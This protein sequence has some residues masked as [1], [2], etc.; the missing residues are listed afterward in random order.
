MHSMAGMMSA[1]LSSHV[2][3]QLIATA[4]AESF[5]D[6][7]CCAC[8][9][10]RFQT[11]STRTANAIHGTDENLVKQIEFVMIE[12]ASVGADAR[13]GLPFDLQY[14]QAI[15]PIPRWAW[16]LANLPLAGAKM[17]RVGK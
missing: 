17:R 2:S 6:A 15:L 14:R 11:E 8:A 7:A 12:R 10:L 13:A 5:G 16:E 9:I 3:K 4:A 1:G